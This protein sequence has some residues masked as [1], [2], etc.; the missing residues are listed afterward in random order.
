M[1]GAI[2]TTYKGRKA[3]EKA[4]ESIQ[5][6]WKGVLVYG[7]T[8]SNYVNFPHLQTA[9][10]CWDYSIKVAKEVS[11]LFPAPMSLAY[12][13]KIYWRFFILT[14]KR[15]MSLACERDG[16]LDTKISKKCVLLQR[17]DN[18]AFVRKVYGDVVMM[19]FNKEK[20]DD[21]L[22]Y[23][24]TE[25]NKLCSSTYPISDFVVTKSVG[26]IGDLEP[27]EGKDKNDKPCHKVGDYKVKLLPTD[28]T[29]REYQFKLKKCNTE[30]EYYLRC[31]PAQVQ[32]AEKMR[33][34]GA[35][36]AAGSRLE[37]VITT[38]GGHNAKQY[39]KVE[40][41]EYF[42]KHRRSLE[43]DYLYYLKQLSNPLDQILDIIYTQDDG[44]GYKLE[45]GFMLNQYKYRLQVRGKMIAELKT[46]FQPTLKFEK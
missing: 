1:P 9:A 37:Y 38:N 11:K 2:V 27:H 4:A 45:T 7:D 40:D 22:Y 39:E 16:V 41:S 12:E 36:V 42:S 35:L 17:R 26:D 29:K 34:R 24:I 10:E 19:I 14:K 18:C 5:R 13:E 21:V 28:K 46:L 32:L 30:Q 20:R 43:I 8:D 33:E 23:I 3:I 25:L 6:D 15:Y 44:S 31:L